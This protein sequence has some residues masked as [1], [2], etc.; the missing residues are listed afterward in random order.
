MQDEHQ[1]E[2]EDVVPTATPEETPEP[3]QA[4]DP[5]QEELNRVESTK[6]TKKEKLEY[7]LKRVQEQLSELGDTNEDENRPLTL[8]DLQAFHAAQAQDT[9]KSL[10]QEIADDAER[11]LVLHHLENTIR[12]S[13]DAY[14]DLRNAQLIVASVKNRMLAEE[15][16]RAATARTRP[17]APAAP[18]KQEGKKPEFTAEQR[19]FIQST[20]LSE[21]DAIKALQS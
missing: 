5:V 14:T 12:P 19:K 10:A 4:S 3:S 16:A 20:G 8:K 11:K 21:E 9:A 7:T 6:R 13:G 15:S 17:S 1:V 18:P 2:T